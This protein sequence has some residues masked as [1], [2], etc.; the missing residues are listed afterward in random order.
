MKVSVIMPVYNG[1]KFISQAI[2]SILNQTFVDFEFIIINDG[3]N[4][5]TEKI[6]AKY[7]DKRIKYFKF[8]KNKGLVYSL[9][10]C[11]KKSKGEFIARMDADD[12]S[13][14]DRFTK[15]V[16]FLDKNES[17]VMC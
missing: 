3:S 11:L 5:K 15:Q 12:I 7:K 6:I 9:N 10:F 8:T 13:M 16:K 4:D 14:P 17:V 1:E 2:E